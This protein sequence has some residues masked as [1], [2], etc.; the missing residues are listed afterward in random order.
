MRFALAT[1]TATLALCGT[2]AGS[3][4][5]SHDGTTTT[6]AG[7]AENDDVLVTFAYF[8][9]GPVSGDGLRVTNGAGVSPGAGC[10]PEGAGAVI[11]PRGDRV[12]ANLGEG[13]D[14]FRFEDYEDVDILTTING[15]GGTDT[16]AGSYRGVLD[17]DAGD[18]TLRPLGYGSQRM[19]GGGGTDTL[20]LT[21]YEGYVLVG[22]GPTTGDEEEYGTR[23]DADVERLR[24][25][26]GEDYFY[27]GPAAG[28]GHT[29][30][31]GPG[32]DAV[33]YDSAAGPVKVVL[34]GSG[35]DNVAADV[36]SVS[37]SPADDEI[38]GTAADNF[39]RGGGGNDRLTGDGGSDSLSGDTGDDAIDAGAGDDIL[40]GDDGN[41]RLG[42]GA[43]EDRLAGGTGGD[44]LR[45][46][47]DKDTVS[48]LEGDFYYDE[49]YVPS[50]SSSSSAPRTPP[51]VT[52][53]L[54][55]RANDGT[56]GEGDD[57]GSDVE[58]VFG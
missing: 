13:A 20:E 12:V 38:V 18:D 31:G 33:S 9:T 44:V 36:E 37:G 40:A 11:C 47:A 26:Y 49:Y 1:I 46:G 58:L 24:G 50:P 51:G 43:G 52:V 27:M 16:L 48:Y 35:T 4:T 29:I 7:D 8:G 42:G 6:I 2:A 39:L 54:D 5:V 30:E 3:T 32:Y 34:G 41:D 23:A 45:G 19:V 28:G 15:Q 17:G 10:V 56:T 57:V 22:G 14:Q 21:G 55:D 25:G 53:A